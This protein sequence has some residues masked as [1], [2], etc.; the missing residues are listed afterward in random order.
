M[1]VTLFGLL[2]LPLCVLCALNPERL[3]QLAIL[4]A[5]FDAA[6]VVTVGDFGVQ[7][8]LLPTT[9]FI[10]YVLLQMLL[11]ARFR[12]AATVWWVVTPF[13]VV[14][15]WAVAGSQL[16]PRLFANQVY[17]WPQRL[18]PPFLAVPLAPSP[19]NLNQDVYVVA[20]C[21]TL[22]T[23]ALYATCTR[24]DLRRLL[25]AYWTSGFL[26]AGLAFWQLASRLASVPF[27]TEF[28]TSNPGYAQLTT[29]TIGAIPRINGSF[30]EPAALAGYLAGIVGASGWS[31]LNG[32]STGVS[33][34]VLPVAVA[35]MVIS[36]STTGYG[37]LAIMVA[38]L[39]GYALLTRSQRLLSRLVLAGLLLLLVAAAGILTLATLVPAV[40]TA[41]SEV[42]GST[43]DKQSSS[44]YQDRTSTDF[45]SLAVVLPTWGL[46]VGW[47]SNRSSS[48][49]PGLLAS[50]GIYGTLALAWFAARVFRVVRRAR[51]SADRALAQVIDAANGSIL[52]VLIAGLLSA[53]AI[54]AVGFYVMLGT[55]I[56]AAVRVSIAVIPRP[57]QSAGSPL[58]APSP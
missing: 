24:F 31:L 18:E 45:D 48:L 56:G 30:T 42:L 15:I 52:A 3:L 53:P 14:T 9:L 37:V 20:D 11:G 19:S 50:L 51:R 58:A 26:A 28:L 39:P 13:V 44:S 46:G 16:M 6:A 49:A 57:A 32:N 34:L 17:V 40:G 41:A 21:L 25:A 1:G 22:V 35:A 33:R 10:G 47:G 4:G 38:A 5:A 54:T 29:Q 43:L 12:G 36:T 2:A 27:P 55:L 8:A 23:T 7:P